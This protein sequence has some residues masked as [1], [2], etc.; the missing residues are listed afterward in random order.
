MGADDRTPVSTF[1]ET[2]PLKRMIW[3]SSDRSWKPISWLLFLYVSF[4]TVGER[5]NE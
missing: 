5:A 4:H 1:Y 2:R 3:S